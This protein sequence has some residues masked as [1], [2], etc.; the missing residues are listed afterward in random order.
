MVP[1]YERYFKCLPS[2][3]KVVDLENWKWDVLIGKDLLIGSKENYVLLDN[4]ASV[5]NEGVFF[6]PRQVMR[7][8]YVSG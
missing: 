8:D 6:F 2:Y 5:L 4:L 3:W 1:S 7:K